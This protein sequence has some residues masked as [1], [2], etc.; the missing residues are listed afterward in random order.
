LCLVLGA[1]LVVFGS[2]CCVV[3][4]E[5]QIGFRTYLGVPEPDPVFGL[6][7]LLLEPGLYLRVPGVHAVE[8]FDRR[9]QRFDS[10]PHEAQTRESELIRLDYYVIW[11]IADPRRFLESF[12]GSS[13]SA[14]SQ[15]DNTSYGELRTALGRASLDELLS[16]QRAEILGAVAGATHAKLSVQGVEIL[17]LQIRSLD[18]PDQNLPQIYARMQSERTRFALRARAE[19]EEQ[20]RALRSRA[21]EQVRVI[22]ADAERE[23]QRLRGEGDAEAS[24][25]YAETYGRDPEFYAFVRSLEAYRKT[26][27][28]RTTLILSRDLPF[29]RYLFEPRSGGA[30]PPPATR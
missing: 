28:E 23:A 26:I 3:I 5:R 9:R 1:A 27:D 25:I 13:T 7:P 30:A 10:P 18:Y 16:A 6:N 15:I 2:Y 24:R 29:L 21:D 12:R 8:R 11:R 14:R 19:G 22:L 4:D 20:S 17:D